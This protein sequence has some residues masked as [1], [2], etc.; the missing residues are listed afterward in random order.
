M[1]PPASLTDGSPVPGDECW[2]TVLTNSRHITKD[3][4]VHA[5]A[6]MGR[7]IAP[8]TGGRAWSHEMSGRLVSL[9]GDLA[10]VEADAQARVQDAQASYAAS[11]GKPASNI[12][13]V[14][15]ACAKADDLRTVF[16]GQFSTDVMYT[17]T[18]DTAHSDIVIF[19]ATTD[20]QIESMRDWLL[21]KLIGITPDKLNLLVTTCGAMVVASAIP[22]TP[23]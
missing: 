3:G 10:A 1:C 2:Y 22:A 11:N 7:R 23:A 15:I 5:Q 19:N 17:P 8:S 6:L 18:A 14:G 16:N 20:V 12:N 13:F 9:A 21:P 4:T